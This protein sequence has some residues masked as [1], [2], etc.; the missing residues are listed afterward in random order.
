MGSGHQLRRASV[1]VVA[2][3]AEGQGR[4]Y[5]QERTR[6]YYLARGSLEEV[7]TLLILAQDLGYLKGQQAKV[8]NSVHDLRRMLNSYVRYLKG[9]AA[10]RQSASPRKRAGRG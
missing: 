7:E 1:S 9:R 3:I 4:Y 8:I 10:D 2:N 5:F 6:S